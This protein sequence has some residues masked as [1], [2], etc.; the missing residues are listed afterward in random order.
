MATGWADSEIPHGPVAAI[1]CKTF[2]ELY[3]IPPPHGTSFVVTKSIKMIDTY[4]VTGMTCSGCEAKVKDLLQDVRGV[5]NV[6]VDKSKEEAVVDMTRYVPIEEFQAKLD[7][8]NKYHI[9]KMAVADQHDHM[10]EE[11]KKSWLATYMPLLLLFG[12]L[13]VVTGL[14]EWRNGGFSAFR[15]MNHFMAGFFLVFSFFKLLDLQGFANS[16][17][18]YDIIARKWKYWGFVYA[19][20]EFALGIAFLT[21]FYPILTNAVTF[22][23]MGMS[24]IGVIQSVMKHQKIKCACLGTV[25]NIPMSTVTIIEDALMMGMSLVMLISMIF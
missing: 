22:I 24:I 4:K 3:N 5:R 14:L 1:I 13:V 15:W 18:M 20:I 12:Y 6:S 21:G 7:P 23:I 16:Y 2:P 8:T 19:I 10:H 11:E 9:S 25:F 17:S